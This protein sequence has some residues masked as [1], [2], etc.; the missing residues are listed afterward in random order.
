MKKIF[1]SPKIL[2][3]KKVKNRN[4]ICH[5]LLFWA[6]LENRS[7]HPVYFN[8]KTCP[9]N[10]L[11]IKSNNNIGKIHQD[12]LWAILFIY[13]FRRIFN[14]ENDVVK[15]FKRPLCGWKFSRERTFQLPVSILRQFALMKNEEALIV[16]HHSVFWMVTHP[17]SNYEI[18]FLT[19][20]YMIS[21]QGH[22][23]YLFI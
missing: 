4:K 15:L 21:G 9:F 11:S 20:K 16:P 18:C 22:C 3:N 2:I 13:F 14:Q 12:C 7:N 5:F 23:Q 8:E 1:Q 19:F 10:Q 6:F 17:T